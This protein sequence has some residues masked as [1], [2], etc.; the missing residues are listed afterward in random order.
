MDLQ[1]YQI[2]NFLSRVDRN[3]HNYGDIDPNVLFDAA[4]DVRNLFVRFAEDKLDDL[5]LD[6]EIE[7]CKDNIARN[8]NDP[9]E[10]KDLEDELQE[11]IDLRTVA[12]DFIERVEDDS[13]R[14][15]DKKILDKLF[16][17]KDSQ[18]YVDINEIADRFYLVNVADEFNWVVDWTWIYLEEEYGIKSNADFAHAVLENKSIDLDIYNYF[19]EDSIEKLVKTPAGKRFLNHYFAKARR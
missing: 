3:F 4:D 7:D 18:L 9:K 14:S 2:K 16:F 19:D 1:E 12:T 5:D 10:L 13:I 17:N 15:K 6:Q 11:L 8:K